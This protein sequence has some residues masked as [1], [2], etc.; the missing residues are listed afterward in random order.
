MKMMTQ[1]N[2]VKL[3]A[4]EWT[5]IEALEYSLSLKD[6]SKIT[7]LPYSVVYRIYQRLKS[8]ASFYFMTDFKKM[9]LLPLYIFFNGDQKINYVNSFTV[10]LRKVY[11][12]KTYNVIYAMVPYVY[13]DEYVRSFGSEPVTIIKGLET[14][15][16]RPSYGSCIYFPYKKVLL[17]VF[18]TWLN[19]IE[20]LSRPVVD[21]PYSYDAPDPIDLAI[22]LGKQKHPYD[23]IL[24]IIRRIRKYD[25]SFPILSKQTI[26]YHYRNHVLKYWLY[27]AINLY[28]NSACVPFRLF[29]FE[30][31]EAHIVARILVKF[32]SFYR[33]LIDR[34][35]AIVFG[36]PPGYVFENV[37]RIISMFDVEMPLGDLI[38]SLENIRRLIKPLWRFVENK[39][40]IWRDIKIKVKN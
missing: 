31:P 34:E 11:G 9:N 17:P 8:R 1:C 39:K 13:Y 5:F 16:W 38:L 7:K 26:S 35:K 29:Y 2:F 20:E 22:I 23:S 10:S 24:S 25:S 19:N 18:D 33:A 40:W 21:W 27:N 12:S 3:N 32:P 14:V 37:Y 28:L 30:G 15:K 36:Q 6:I 4:K